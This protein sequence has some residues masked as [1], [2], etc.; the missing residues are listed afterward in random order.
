M[1]ANPGSPSQRPQVLYFA[2]QHAREAMGMMTLMYFMWYLTER[3]GSDPE[4]TYLLDNRELW[5]IPIVNVD[6]Y[7]ANRRMK[8]NGGG[9]RRKNMRYVSLDTDNNGVDLNRN[10]GAH[11]GYDN[12]GSSPNTQWV[13]YRGL[14]PFSEPETQVISEFFKTKSFRFVLEY[15]SYWNTVFCVPG[16]IR[17]ESPDSL[18]FREYVRELTRVNHYANG[19]S[20]GAYP[21][22]GYSSDWFYENPPSL[23]KTF[24]FL[25]EVGGDADGFWPATSRI[26]PIATENLRANLFSAWAGGAYVKLVDATIVDSSGDGDLVPGEPFT[27]RFS[28]RNFGQ[29]P[30][31]RDEFLRELII[32]AD[33]RDP[34]SRWTSPRSC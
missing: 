17:G 3:Y 11:W 1:T 30:V 14:G 13:D 5:F 18:L 34:H 27:A 23:G 31:G 25:S 32:A 20:P 29:D 9:M 19:S 10:W 26:L 24:P 15:H 33:R 16:Y 22:N 12:E 28:I 4:V 8:P 7:E 2:M 6:G 21:C